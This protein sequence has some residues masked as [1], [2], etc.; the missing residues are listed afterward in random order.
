MKTTNP[1]KEIITK[2]LERLHFEAETFLIKYLSGLGVEITS[3]A[4]V[5]IDQAQKTVAL[6]YGEG[7]KLIEIVGAG[8]FAGISSIQLAVWNGDRKTKPIE[9]G[10]R[11]VAHY[12]LLN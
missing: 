4:D 1:T 12:E 10:P 5:V 2:A 7:F 11:F 6:I 8:T 9:I 3:D